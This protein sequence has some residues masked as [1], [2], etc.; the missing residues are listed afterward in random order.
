MKEK[1]PSI[2]EVAK[3]AGVS[4]ATVSRVFNNN[5]KVDPELKEKVL[6][7]SKKLCYK[8][9]YYAKALIQGKTD[10]VGL[11]LTKFEI[12]HYSGILQGIESVLNAAGFKFFVTSSRYEMEKEREKIQLFLDLNFAGIIIISVGLSDEEIVKFSKKGTP[13]LVYDRLVKGIKNNCIYFDNFGIEKKITNYLI[14]N[15]HRRIAHIGG[16]ETLPVYNERKKGYISALENNGIP[17][18]ESLII[19]CDKTGFSTKEGYRSALELLKRGKF[20]ALICQ[21]DQTAIGA[22]SAIN[23]KGLRVP[24]DISIVGFGNVP[25]SPYVSPPLTTIQFDRTGMG[26]L[27][28]RK[29]INLIENNEENL[30]LPKFEI[31]HR[32]SVKKLK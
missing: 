25:E 19:T 26:K 10:F 23:S 8:T 21:N 3:L 31:I 6:A 15:G 24:D 22:I 14:E 18:D 20:T 12:R 16:S 29:M 2:L 9:N 17:V 11:L 30:E 7:A 32:S 13:L 1:K 5:P 27:I 28:G 4:P